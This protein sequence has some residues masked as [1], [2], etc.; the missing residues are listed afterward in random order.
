MISYIVRVDMTISKPYIGT[1]I[2]ILIKFH[3]HILKLS[4]Y[5]LNLLPQNDTWLFYADLS[6]H[7][8]SK[9]KTSA[10]YHRILA[11]LTKVY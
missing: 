9:L 2:L 6:T 7:I 4:K 10:L 8:K 5:N 11:N 3:V 1:R